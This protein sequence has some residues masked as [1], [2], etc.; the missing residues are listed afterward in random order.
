[1]ALV[2]FQDTR[3]THVIMGIVLCV[4]LYTVFGVFIHLATHDQ[5]GSP[6]ALSYRENGE[7]GTITNDERDDFLAQVLPEDNEHITILSDG[8]RGVVVRVVDG[9][10]IE[11]DLN[12][13]RESVR[14]IGIDTPET[15]HPQKP[16]ECFG[17]EASA[18]NRALVEGKSVVLVRDVTDRDKYGRLLRYVYIDDLFVNEVLVREGYATVYTYPPDVREDVRLREAERVARRE[19]VGLW[20]LVCGVSEAEVPHVSNQHGV[21]SIK[22]NINAKGEKIYH[23]LG[24]S[25]YEKT[26]VQEGSGERWFCTEA[27][28]VSAG[29][30][31]AK[32]CL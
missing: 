13:V 20:G 8:E 5:G 18:R 19:G 24:C 32:N 12:G 17:R 28:A 30:R 10:T 31:K 15:V 9:D 7:E 11:V 16:V 2:R 4:F 22:G 27:E 23:M 6:D 25:F 21:C 14:Y 29:W 26:I 3:L 1:M